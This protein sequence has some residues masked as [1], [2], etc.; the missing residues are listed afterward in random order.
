MNPETGIDRAWLRLSVQS[1]H[2]VLGTLV[3]M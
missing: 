3:L 2:S 1:F